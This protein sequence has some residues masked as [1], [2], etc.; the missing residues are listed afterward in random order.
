MTAKDDNPMRL[1]LK[2]DSY[3]IRPGETCEIS[4]QAP[5]AFLPD[6]FATSGETKGLEIEA[7]RIGV[8]I[9]WPNKMGG[10]PIACEIFHRQHGCN[11]VVLPKVHAGFMVAFR[12]INKSDKLAQFYAELSGEVIK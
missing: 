2:F 6:D 3:P 4:T 7:M 1:C 12:V 11:A 8:N 9:I 10:H 5:T